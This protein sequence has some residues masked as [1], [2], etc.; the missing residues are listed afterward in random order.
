MGGLYNPGPEYVM[1]VIA[2]VTERVAAAFP[3]VPILPALGN[4]EFSPNYGVWSN[5]SLFYANALGVWGRFLA[6]AERKTFA[7]GGYYFRDFRD[8][9]L[10]ILNTVI[11]H[12]NREYTGNTDPNGQFEWL[13]RVC[14]EAMKRRL[15]V[16][17]FFHVPPSAGSRRN[18]H[19]QG[20]HEAYA[21][22]FAE[23]YYRH[24]FTMFCGH[25]HMDVLLP[26]TNRFNKRGGYILSAPS[27][28][29]KHD[30]NPAFRVIRVRN[31]DACDYEQYYADIVANPK[32]K[33]EWKLEYSFR[34]LYGAKNLSE[35]ELHAVA[36]A[37][38][39]NS[40]IMWKYRE[41][42]YARNYDRRA[43]HW[44]MLDALSKADLQNCL[45]ES[46]ELTAP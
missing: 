19:T 37:I 10:I 7:N 11:Y 15:G 24:R 22:A 33:L 29:P 30:S 26:L 38:K 41:M 40:E 44:C 34:K 45:A 14:K 17:V 35:A 1:S 6:P 4:S 8:T 46:A 31:G 23:L 13:D 36:T 39:T 25:L 9:R 3:R 28:S 5:D 12:V 27:L 32:G 43:F 20:W 2:T 16:L 21:D 18:L 42:M